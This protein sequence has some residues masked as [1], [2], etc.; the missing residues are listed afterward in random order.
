LVG[1]S[2]LVVRGSSMAVNAASE[3]RRPVR[4]YVKIPDPATEV[5]K[6]AGIEET[7][8][9]FIFRFGYFYWRVKASAFDL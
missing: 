9:Y 1:G 8:L 5:L 7:I 2:S 4:Q 6:S 3:R